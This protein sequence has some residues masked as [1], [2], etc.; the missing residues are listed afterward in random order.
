MGNSP[1]HLSIFSQALDRVAFLAY[2][3]GAV[4]PFA[5][6]AW[7]AQ[8]YVLPQLPAGAPSIAA[9]AALGALGFLSL[10]AFLALRRVARGTLS[11]LDA[12][13]RRLETLLDGS[14][15]LADARF[16]DEV[17]R[18]AASCAAA[19][20]GAPGAFLFARDPE[21]PEEAPRLVATGGDDAMDRYRAGRSQLE[22][23]VAPVLE[24][25]MPALLRTP[26]PPA[27]APSRRCR[28]RRPPARRRAAPRSRSSAG[29]GRFDAS[30][31][32]LLATVAAQ[33]SVAES[34]AE[35]RDSQRNFFVHVTEILIAA[36]DA[37]LGEGEGHARRVAHL[38]VCL[39]RELGFDERR[40]ERLH[41]AA[42]LHDVGMLK[43]DTR[44]P[45]PKSAY[46]SHV[47][48]GQRMLA[49][50][51]V[52]EDL[53]PFVMHHHECWDGT[54]YPE[55]LAGEDIPLEARIIGLA[56]A[57]DSLTSGSATRP[58]GS[59]D[60]ALA[61][62]RDGRGSR[63]EPRLAD[64]FLALVERGLIEGPREG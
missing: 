13:K 37:Q 52:W 20:S 35:L 39:G 45:Q 33:L 15:A 32:R 31:L 7:V 1:H 51:R 38:S 48:L 23:L 60:E 4:V 61:K 9:G 62:V 36:F 27:C 43:L 2:F 6:L 53:A 47:V 30:H 41:F 54:G 57:V 10:A 50:I 55:G 59:F 46:R 22:E 12:D 63:F 44:R 8:R 18:R 56:E 29:S 40:L 58:P 28:C 3:L 49:R 42:L 34:N 16:A 24:Q 26:R 21:K 25:G 19:V 14:L 11:R 5:A 17:H 64:L